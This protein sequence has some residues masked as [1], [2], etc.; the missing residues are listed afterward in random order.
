MLTIQYLRSNTED[1][2]KR[3]AKKHFPAKEI[4]EKIIVTDAD[5]RQAQVQLEQQLSQSNL[6]SKE[7]GQLFSQGKKE[8][9]EEK[10]TQSIQLREEA[11]KLEERLKELEQELHQLLVKLPNVPHNDVPEGK[12]PEENVE[13]RNGGI[14]PQLYEGAKPH[15]ELTSQYDIIDFELGNK[16]TGSGFP[17]YKGKGAK[18]QRALISFF[19]GLAL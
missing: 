19:L 5:R 8:E 15:W 18:L 3:L 9:A 10:R 16:V 11:K 7:I 6:L 12:T 1:A 13:V 2:I 4:I 17:F 14:M